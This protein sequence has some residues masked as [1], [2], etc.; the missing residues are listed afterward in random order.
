MQ[1]FE[2]NHFSERIVLVKTYSKIL[3]FIEKIV[4][5]ILFVALAV[6]CVVAFVEVF[7]RY[8]F[9]KSFMWADELNR[10]LLIWITF[11]GASVLFR[12]RR[13]VHFDFGHDKLPPKVLAVITLI[14]HCI[15]FAM[16]VYL[17]VRAYRFAFSP[18]LIKQHSITIG[19]SMSLVYAVVPISFT[20]MILYGIEQFPKLVKDVF[21]KEE[22]ATREVWD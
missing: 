11:L 15:A 7:R 19:I 12:K 22:K 9:N 13:L 3:D 20:L 1:Q 10:Y 18:I 5:A 16:L 17:A 6:I 8:I 2:V 14:A 4:K 21:H